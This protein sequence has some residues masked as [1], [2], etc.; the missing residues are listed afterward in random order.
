MNRK[1]YYVLLFLMDILAI[2]ALCVGVWTFNTNKKM[3]MIRDVEINED[4]EAES[5]FVFRINNMLPGDAHTYTVNLTATA[6]ELH[7]IK[8]EFTEKGDVSLAKFIT[9][10]V[11]LDD[12][13][14]E[15]L[16]LSE[17][18]EDNGFELE[19]DFSE[20]QN[21]ALSITYTL[22]LETTDEAQGAI[23]KFDATL[24]VSRIIE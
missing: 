6:I 10:D 18:L 3:S 7:S 19:V 16:S 24:K 23:A 17:L 14:I 8:M 11:L 15:Q 1:L 13:P 2:S 20:I 12:Q 5:K 21:R 9:V 4:G 22:P